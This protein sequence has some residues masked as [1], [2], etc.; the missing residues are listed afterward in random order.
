M[1][2]KENF[3]TVLILMVVCV[4]TPYV[5]GIDPVCFNCHC[6]SYELDRSIRCK[7]AV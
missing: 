5:D 7:N 4:I 2:T 6:S 3:I 1:Q